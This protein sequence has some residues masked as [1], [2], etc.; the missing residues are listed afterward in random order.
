MQ[1][2]GHLKRE[3]PNY[4][5]GKDKMLT[6]TLSDYESSTSNLGDSCDSDE[7]YSAFMDVR[8]Y[9]F[10]MLGTY[11]TILCNWLIL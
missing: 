2:H 6:T 3:C 9:V 1:G 5:R 11:V 8:T 7:N 4:L 10:H